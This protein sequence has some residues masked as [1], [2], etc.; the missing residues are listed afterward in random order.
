MSTNRKLIPDKKSLF[1]S[2]LIVLVVAYAI[3][4][5]FNSFGTIAQI[6]SVAAGIFIVVPILKMPIEIEDNENSIIVKTIVSSKHFLK[7]DYSIQRIS[8]KSTFSIRLLATSIFLHWGYF[9]T[10]SLGIYYALCVNP[11]NTILL[12]RKVDGKKIVI[13]SPWI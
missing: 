11:S 1:Y 10:K 7:K 6:I 8:E 12:I 9:W 2:F 5:A 3:Y 13:D 4:Y